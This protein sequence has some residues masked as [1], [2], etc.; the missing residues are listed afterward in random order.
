MTLLRSIRRK[1]VLS[2]ALALLVITGVLLAFWPREPHYQGRPLSYWLDRLPEYTQSPF[3]DAAADYLGVCPTVSRT[4][5]RVSRKEMVMAVKALDASGG[6]SLPMLVRRL[7]S[8]ITR[9]ATW[10]FQARLAARK[11][12]LCSMVTLPPPPAIASMICRNQAAFAIVDLG[13]RSKPILPA[14]ATLAKNDSDP[15]VRASALEVLRRL[16]PAAQASGKAAAK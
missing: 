6:Q 14:V 5:Q 11:F 7:D 10:L 8:K 9:Q 2:G 3:A 13:D 16:A 15:A 1:P 4:G 12:G